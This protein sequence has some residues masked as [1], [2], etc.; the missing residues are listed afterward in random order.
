[1]SMEMA[2]LCKNA[3]NNQLQQSIYLLSEQCH[4]YK[5]PNNI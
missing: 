4:L 5:A 2:Q 1:M 3:D